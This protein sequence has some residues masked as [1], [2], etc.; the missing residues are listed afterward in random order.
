MKLTFFSL[1]I[2]SIVF[3]SAC[4]V[5]GERPIVPANKPDELGV[6]NYVVNEQWA[7]SAS[8]IADDLSNFQGHSMVAAKTSTYE[9]W[10]SPT[11][12]CM[13][14]F[15]DTEA[16]TAKY[17]LNIGDIKIGG[18]SIQEQAIPR[19]QD[20]PMFFG[21]NGHLPAGAYHIVNSGNAQGSFVF[22]QDFTIPEAGSQIK[23]ISGVDGPS[24]EL[25]SPAVVG[26]SDPRFIASINKMDSV[27]IEYT[28]PE[29][30][31]Y[32]RT[33][34]F[35]NSGL[36]GG[37]VTCYSTPLTPTVIPAGAL[38]YFRSTDDAT[39]FVDFVSASIKTDAPGIQESFIQSYTRHVHGMREFYIDHHNTTARFGKLRIE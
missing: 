34:I 35:D 17:N 9:K 1:Q 10:K 36:N 29:N 22:N 4:K 16:V 23:I 19:F 37:S 5:A 25:P 27:R 11:N 32:V 6:F 12:T 21:F 15:E 30:I 28:P 33:T 13:F 7:L 39:L 20:D 26:E 31:D 18:F 24:Q 14:T 8:S 38:R 2:S 3:L